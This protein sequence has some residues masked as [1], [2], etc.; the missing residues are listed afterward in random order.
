[1]AEHRQ[2]PSG[3]EGMRATDLEA[4]EAGWA[5]RPIGVVRSPFTDRRS[6]P[7]QAV[8]GRGVKGRI[9]L[10]PDRGYEHA[11]A[12]LD[13]WSHIWVVF[14][15]HLHQGWRP[16]VL[17][18]RSR[19]KRGVFATRA[20]RRPNPIGLSAVKLTAV[21]G[22]TLHVEDLDIVDGTPVL[23]IK[24][25]VPYCDALASAT[26]GWLG[27]AFEP[28]DP[29]PRFRVSWSAHAEAQLAWLAARATI[30]LRGM[31]EAVLSQGPAPHP[32]RRIRAEGDRFRLGVKDFRLWFRVAGDE[33]QVLEIGSGYRRRVLESAE[34]TATEATPLEVHRAFVARFDPSG[35]GR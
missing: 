11:L 22:R 10:L 29:G 18:P 1:M 35:P 14:W 2:D 5:L 4:G 8:A 23:D 16:K 12:D 27:A 21:Q 26:S 34:A 13:S 20:P 19:I 28:L 7:R 31:A 17:P 33:V 25:Y 15:F 3:G 32:Y 9:E 6:A 30:D 24:P